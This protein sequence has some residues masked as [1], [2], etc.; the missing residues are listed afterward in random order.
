MGSERGEERRGRREGAVAGSGTG[1]GGARAGAGSL[2]EA[3][4]NNMFML[5]FPK[6]LTQV[7]ICLTLINNKT[8]Y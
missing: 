6:S 7:F 2:E 3:G 4:N 1:E 8:H 5:N